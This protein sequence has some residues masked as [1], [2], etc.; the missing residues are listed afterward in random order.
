M[1][2]LLRSVGKHLKMQLHS[3]ARGINLSA[4]YLL[5]ACATPGS[6]GICVLRHSWVPV[7][8]LPSHFSVFRFHSLVSMEA[9]GRN[10]PTP[11]PSEIWSMCTCSSNE[12][13]SQTQ[14]CIK[15]SFLFLLS[16]ERKNADSEFLIKCTTQSREEK[17]P[18]AR[19]RGPPCPWPLPANDGL[20]L[21]M[22]TTYGS[23]PRIVLQQQEMQV[24]VS[25]D[26]GGETLIFS[27]V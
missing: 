19:G 3:L 9:A 18:L 10:C 4:S 20:S 13:Q 2:S 22:S 11:P 24:L 1:L 23:F 25:L 15:C 26:G 5:S 8:A 21:Y 12:A 14:V 7:L 17:Y 6:V 16:W 27:R